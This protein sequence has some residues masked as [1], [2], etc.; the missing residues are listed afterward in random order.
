MNQFPLSRKEDLAEENEK[1]TSFL[2]ENWI[3]RTNEVDSFS[4]RLLASYGEINNEL[5]YGWLNLL[6]HYLDAQKDYSNQFQTVFLPEPMRKI[7]KQNTDLWIHTTQNI[8][9]MC[10]DCLKNIKNSIRAVNNG[11]V[12]SLQNAQRLYAIYA[13]ADKADDIPELEA[14]ASK[15]ELKISKK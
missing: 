11:F 7:V 13:Q 6:Q 2:K 15:T 12:L 1:I 5:I 8:D 10:I 3:R 14:E 4:K 9:S